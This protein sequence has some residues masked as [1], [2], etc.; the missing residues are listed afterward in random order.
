MSKWTTVSTR[1][2]EPE[3]K[4]QPEW[5][6]WSMIDLYVTNFA[7]R[8]FSSFFFLYKPEPGAADAEN[9]LPLD[10]LI[11]S[12]AGALKLFYPFAG[13]LLTDESGKARAF[14]NNQG[15]VFTHKRYDGIVSDLIDEEDFQPNE[16]ISGL[17][18]VDPEVLLSEPSGLPTLIIQVTDFQCGTRCLSTT[19]SHLLADGF[20]GTHFLASWAQLSRGESVSLMPVHNR[21]LLMP[22]KSSP[23]LDGAPVKFLNTSIKEPLP[24]KFTIPEGGVV[25]IVMK[26][27]KKR[28]DELKAEALLHADGETLSTADC[29]SAHL[30]RLIIKNRNLKD[31]EPTRFYTA[32]DGR[33]RLKDFPA[34]YFGNV[35]TAPVVVMTVG[36]LLSKRL[37]QVAA[38]IHT[39]IK[40]MDDEVIRGMVDWLSVNEFHL[41]CIG[42]EPFMPGD[43]TAN[44]H[45]VS[46]SWIN[47]F[48]F[49]ELDF[50]G[51][52]PSAVYRNATGTGAFSLGR[53]HVL[54]T[55]TTSTE[56]DLK[57]SVFGEKSILERVEIEKQGAALEHEAEFFK[58]II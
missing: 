38:A 6:E 36:E 24:V 22:R 58:E 28:I 1:L 21:S 10:R 4:R 49:F 39:A 35:L 33:S 20:S 7:T 48:P 5:I 25:T 11:E 41:D 43:P 55:V 12:L 30:W 3:V 52:K 9:V 40:A 19:Y 34:G 17:C 56:G 18:D 45:S 50:G 8:A 57:V 47:R 29:I 42:D 31:N 46:A 2:V 14:C 26:L 54:P 15:A 27:S 16:Y 32:V 37:G 53:F 13:R 51:G 44:L 23:V